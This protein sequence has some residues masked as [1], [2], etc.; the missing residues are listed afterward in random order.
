MA[1]SIP[2]NGLFRQQP[3]AG[4]SFV[5]VTDERFTSRSKFISSDYLLS[6]I[7]YDPSQVHKRLGDGFYEQRLV[8]EQMLK[9]TGRP[10]VRGE[11]AMAQYQ[12]LMN[13]GIKV[14]QDAH[15]VPGVALTPAQIA[16]L[17][18]DI[19]WLVSETVATADGPQTAWVPKV[20]LAD[21]HAAPHR[22]RRADWRWHPAAFRRQHRQRRQPVCRQGAHH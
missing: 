9:L 20:Y 11:N 22:R 17:R 15:L 2:N 14:A 8:R 7:G 3:V 12:S 5:V 16:A 10:S 18:Q 1:T 13:N 21:T 4:S 6:R 19:V